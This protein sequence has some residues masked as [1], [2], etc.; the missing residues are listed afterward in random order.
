D[1]TLDDVRVE[2]AMQYTTSEEE[3]VR[4]YA[5]NAYNAGG[6]VH[7]S[8]FRSALTRALNTYGTKENLFKNDLQPTGED[9]R[10]GLTALVSVQV[11][12][13][14]F[15]SQTKVRLN[16]PEVEGI[17]V[18]VVHEQLA[19]YLEENPKD[20]QRLFKKVVLAAEAR[21]AAA[22]A[23]RALKDRKIILSS[24]GLP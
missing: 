7:L 1:R 2:V 17:V 5:N 20:A 8:G 22:K 11:P 18:T 12:E 3:R 9:Y 6:G 23:K 15:E 21:E 19:T 16:N 13:P 10:E 14:Q 4:C 24:G